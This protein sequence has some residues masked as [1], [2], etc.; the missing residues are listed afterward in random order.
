MRNGMTLYHNLYDTFLQ[1][2]TDEHVG[3]L[4]KVLFE[5]SIDSSYGIVPDD[6]KIEEFEGFEL[7]ALKEGLREVKYSSVS[8]ISRCI[9][10]KMAKFEK[11]KSKWDAIKRRDDLYLQSNVGLSREEIRYI[12]ETEGILQAD[13]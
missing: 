3:K 4:V 2:M 13:V 12:R 7:G 11:D 1:Y 6:P 10:S 8:H 5:Y 9:N